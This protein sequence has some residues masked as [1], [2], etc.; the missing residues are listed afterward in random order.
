MKSITFK[1]RDNWS[2]WEWRT[3][4]C[5]VES[6]EECIK[7]YGLNDAGVEYEILSVEEEA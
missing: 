1:Y 6:V 4:H 5:S 3:Q 2:N 7:I